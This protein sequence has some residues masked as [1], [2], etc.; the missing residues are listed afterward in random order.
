MILV[1]LELLFVCM[2][3]RNESAV[4]VEHLFGGIATAAFL[5]AIGFFVAEVTDNVVLGYMGAMLYYLLSYGAKDKLG[6]FYLFYMCAGHFD[7]K[8]WLLFGAAVLIIVT[9]IVM[10]IRRKR[11]GY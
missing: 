8:W 4:T 11:L 1:V 5:G 2:L 7:E 10:Q 6:K 3:A 9:F